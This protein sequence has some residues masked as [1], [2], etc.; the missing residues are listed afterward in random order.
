MIRWVPARTAWLLAMAV[1]GILSI[2]WALTPATAAVA[3]ALGFGTFLLGHTVG[4][5]RGV[6]HGS[7]RS[8]K[9][10][11]AALV[12]VFVLTG[13]GGPLRWI[14]VHNQRDVWQNRAWAPDWFRYDHGPFLDAWW[15]LNTAYDEPVDYLRA[16]LAADPWLRVLDRTWFL[17]VGA[18]FGALWALGGADHLLI[19]GFLRVAVGIVMHWYVGYEAHARG[20][21]RF[22]IAGAVETG[23]NR[24]LLGVLSL[25]EGFHN[26]HHAR[27]SSARIGLLPHEIDAGWLLIRAFEALGLVWDVKRPEDVPIRGSGLVAR[28][29]E[30]RGGQAME[31]RVDLVRR[32]AGA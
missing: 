4:L 2:P 17:H 32:E 10:L 9:W 5:H 6:L 25:G 28:G 18:S 30:N 11:R 27:P 21:V 8:G 16:D 1:P 29:G 15:N 3:A 7:Y 12:W 20:E 14:A 26:N 31:R 23:R 22:P 13:M 19:G 24:W